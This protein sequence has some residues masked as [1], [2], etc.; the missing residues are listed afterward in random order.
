MAYDLTA[1]TASTHEKIQ[2]KFTDNISKKRPLFVKAKST[3]GM[4][5]E[6]GGR[7][8]DFPVITKKGV[9]S[10]YYGDDKFDISRQEGLEKFT[11][12]W[13]QWYGSVRIDGIEEIMNSGPSKAADLLNGRFKQQE[14]TTAENFESMLFADGTGNV[15]GDGTA[16]DWEGLQSLVADDPTTGTIGG[17][18]RATN[19]NIRNQAYTTAVTAFN[20]SQAGRNAMTTLWASCVHGSRRPN[21]GVTTV[22]I[23]TL[24]NLSL[25]Q[26]E[27]VLIDAD[28]DLTSAGFPNVAFMGFP[29]T[30]SDQAPADRM[31]FLRFAKPASDGGIFLVIHRDRNFKL[32]PFITP[33][34]QDIRVAIALTAGQLCTDAPYLNGV[35]T[36]ITG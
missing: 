9:G 8:L 2:K 32:R 21:F 20:T 36:N 3:G 23:W 19:S 18:S 13:K 24:Y 34:D 6:D 16:R 30:M 28:N 29:I 22:A 25:Q 33:I 1:I 27:R 26:N 31:Y 14:D 5:L 17:L 7:A 12:S 35:I 10:S 11:Y 4:A 15:G